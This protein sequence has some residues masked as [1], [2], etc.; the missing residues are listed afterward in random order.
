MWGVPWVKAFSV[1]PSNAVMIGKNSW[2]YYMIDGDGQQLRHSQLFSPEEVM[3][4]G[5]TLEQQRVWLARRGIKYTFV[6]APSKCSIYP[7][8]VPDSYFLLNKNSRADQLISY[9]KEHTSVDVVD[10]RQPLVDKKSAGQLYFRTDTHW[11]KFGA[12]LASNIVIKHLQEKLPNLK[13]N[14][15]ESDYTITT[16]LVEHG[17]LT[18]MMGVDGLLTEE[19]PV[20]SRKNGEGWKLSHNP[21]QPVKG[22]PRDAYKPLAT[23]CFPLDDKLP[24]AM[25][26]GD[27][28]SVPLVAYLA[29]SFNRIYLDRDSHNHPD[30]RFPI[31]TIQ[32]EKPDLVI[33][34]VTERKL[35]LPA[36]T[37]PPELCEQLSQ[38]KP[39]MY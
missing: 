9:L 30:C 22:D 19:Q 36:T 27:S 16:K 15:L 26:I 23:Q 1:S 38:S 2:L 8:N 11:N 18:L 6:L 7:E 24:K 20:L 35:I 32:S 33:Q 37:N 25:L 28:F 13:A 12:M 34:E 3:A 17:D 14:A 21:P 4:W 5:T 39:S 29:P 31:A 10:L